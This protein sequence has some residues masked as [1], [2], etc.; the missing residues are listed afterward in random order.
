MDGL[1]TKSSTSTVWTIPAPP[2]PPPAVAVR[3]VI[4]QGRLQLGV[5]I[6]AFAVHAESTS[7]ITSIT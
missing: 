3:L 6:L 5:V 7:S 1:N 4:L 2:P